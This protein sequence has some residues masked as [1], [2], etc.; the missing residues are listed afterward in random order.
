MSGGNE[1]TT[2]FVMSKLTTVWLKEKY[3]SKE[4]GHVRPIRC[5]KAINKKK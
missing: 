1:I 4:M 5:H 3:L 2:K